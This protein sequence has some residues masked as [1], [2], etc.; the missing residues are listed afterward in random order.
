VVGTTLCR[1]HGTK[2]DEPAEPKRRSPATP[3]GSAEPE[4]EQEAAE[5]ESV[6]PARFRAELAADLGDDYELVR[7][8]LRDA[9]AGEKSVWGDCPDCKHRVRVKVADHGAL[10]KA[11]ELWAVLGLGRASAGRGAVGA[12]DVSE[13]EAKPFEEMSDDELTVLAYYGSTAEERAGLREDQR[14]L[15]AAVERVLAESAA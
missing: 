11:L 5:R 14:R 9:M 6:D 8:V 4:V 12:P 13:L 3:A 1:H 15:L 2:A 10:L 7:S